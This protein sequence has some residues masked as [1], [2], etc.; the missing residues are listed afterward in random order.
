MA[1]RKGGE[2]V[3]FTPSFIPF[4]AMFQ[5]VMIP[6]RLVDWLFY[7]IRIRGRRTLQH[8]RSAILVSNHT[9]ILDPA[10]IAHSL[11]RRRTYFTMLEET[12]LIPWLGTF[13]RLLGAL[14][15]PEGVGSMLSL[16]NAARR[17]IAEMGLLH[18]FPEGECYRWN[19]DIQP[20]RPGAF[21]LAC[22]LG[23]PV[24]PMTTVLHE[25]RW[26]G[27]TSVRV[28][29]RVI[30]VP[31]L[32]TVVI[33]RPVPPPAAAFSADPHTLRGA[34]MRMAAEVRQAMQDTVDALGGSR[35]IYRG[36]M[37]RLV[38]KPSAAQPGPGV[39]RVV[40]AI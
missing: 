4:Q 34:A 21:L 12:A 32:V 11:G 5:L 28:A 30:P 26:R 19:Q 1:Y 16:E 6:I 23:L 8:C 22:R 37:P 18:F 35:E 29:G 14:P 20:F 33:G 13:V 3:G 31:P 9:L 17:A 15:I 40:R 24:I 39:P 27:R 38:K 36:K 10:V 2:I 7:R 25:R